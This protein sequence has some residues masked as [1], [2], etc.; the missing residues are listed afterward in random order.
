MR[1]LIWLHCLRQAQAERSVILSCTGSIILYGVVLFKLI[2]V[3]AGY[4]FLGW[5]GVLLGL[6]IG[7]FID[8]IRVYGSGGMNPLQNALRRAVFLETV[9][10]RWASW[11]RRMGVF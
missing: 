7:S 2:G 8:R 1:A 5:W 3:I 4:Y 6:F 9:F 10:S 11:P